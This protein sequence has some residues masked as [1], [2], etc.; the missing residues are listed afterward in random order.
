M[1][2]NFAVKEHQTFRGRIKMTI[3]V[4]VNLLNIISALKT[5]FF[6][7][8]RLTL[9]WLY[10]CCSTDWIQF[11]SPSSSPINTKVDEQTLINIELFDNLWKSWLTSVAHRW[12]YWELHGLRTLGV[13][14][15]RVITVI[16]CQC[17]SY[18]KPRLA[19]AQFLTAKLKTWATDMTLG[20]WS[21]SLMW[22]YLLS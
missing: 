3:I 15:I 18:L 13:K 22:V 14:G 8:E 4:E 11:S 7:T 17:K 10:W 12:L 2:V 9:F 21:F 6:V 20:D 1:S 16:M 5:A 19:I